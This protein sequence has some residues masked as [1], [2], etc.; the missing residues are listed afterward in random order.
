MKVVTEVL[1]NTLHTILIWRMFSMPE[2]FVGGNRFTDDRHSSDTIRDDT[3][4]GLLSTGNRNTHL[5]IGKNICL[6]GVMGK[7]VG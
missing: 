3:E 1:F 4:H 7:K 2:Q 5:W 6:A